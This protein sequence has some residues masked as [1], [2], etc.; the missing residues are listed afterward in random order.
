[1]LMGSGGGEKLAIVGGS[2]FAENL[3]LLKSRFSLNQSGYFGNRGSGSTSTRVY[4]CSN[5]T[6]VAF[7]FASIAS[8]GSLMV[9]TIRGKGLR[10]RMRDGAVVSY[11]FYS[12]SDGSPV[13]ELRHLCTADVKEQKIHFVKK[14]K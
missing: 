14:V 8:A 13:V 1:M 11:R 9:D 12:G 10:Y 7:D 6:R 5:P 4:E 3:E 2:T